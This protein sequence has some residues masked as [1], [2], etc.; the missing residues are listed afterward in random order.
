MYIIIYIHSCNG[1]H[2][3]IPGGITEARAATEAGAI[4]FPGELGSVFDGLRLERIGCFN[5]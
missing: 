5:V 3:R 2:V 1:Q 4:F